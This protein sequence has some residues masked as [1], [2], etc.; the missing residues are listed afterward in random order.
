MFNIFKIFKKHKKIAPATYFNNLKKQIVKIDDSNLST[1][2]DNALNLLNSY[3]EAGQE[4]AIKQTI[5]NLEC[6]QKEKKL[7]DLGINTYIYR[8]DIEE[9]IDSVASKVIKIIELEKYPRKIPSNVAI[10]IKNT[11][12]IFDQIYIVFTD[13]TGAIEKKVEKEKREK[14]PICFGTFQS[15]KD[16]LVIDRFYFLGDWVDEYCDLTIDKMIKEMKSVKD[17]DIKYTINTKQD[18][19]A[20]KQNYFKKIKK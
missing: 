19:E 11:K 3:V 1:M 4:E 6:I 10:N 18:I 9:Y 15:G 12:D 13:Y 2:H 20:L 17:K 5:L 8:Q 16:N 7:I 14:D